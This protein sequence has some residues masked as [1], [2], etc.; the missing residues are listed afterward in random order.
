MFSSNPYSLKIASVFNG[1]CLSLTLLGKYASRY[2]YYS[3]N[4]KT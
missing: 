2:S 3:L 4:N 1:V